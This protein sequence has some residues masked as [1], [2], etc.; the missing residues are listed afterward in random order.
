MVKK[1]VER[2][3][4]KAT[5]SNN[6]FQIRA[7][8]M[9]R[10]EYGYEPNWACLGTPTSNTVPKPPILHFK[11]KYIASVSL[12]RFRAGFLSIVISLS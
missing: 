6:L 5:S 12:T 4:A 11:F 7:L 1:R 3:A 2:P 10:A 8:V 9:K